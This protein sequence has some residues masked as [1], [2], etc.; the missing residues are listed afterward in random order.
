MKLLVIG[1]A[2]HGKDTVCE[3]LQRDHGL[4]FASSSHFVGK[5][6]VW[7]RLKGFYPNFEAMFDDR[8]RHRALWKDLIA[9]YCAD[10]PARTAEGMLD[11][12][13]DV[14]CGMRARREFKA[15]RPLFDAVLWV[16]RSSCVPS[17]PWSSME[18]NRRDADFVVVNDGNLARLE[19][20]VAAVYSK[21]ETRVSHCQPK[22]GL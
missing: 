8:V 3:I 12:G 18:L 6:V 11:A 7:E 16:D 2:R 15:A 14:Y 22:M 17:E 13:F 20:E 1:H 5:K 21:C 19:A 9:Q 4:K 10:N